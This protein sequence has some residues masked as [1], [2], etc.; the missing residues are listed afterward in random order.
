MAAEEAGRRGIPSL[1]NPSSASSEGQQE[2]IASDVTQ[3]RPPSCSL[4]SLSFFLLRLPAC[5]LGAP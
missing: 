2:H 5:V 1:L 4:P 3:V